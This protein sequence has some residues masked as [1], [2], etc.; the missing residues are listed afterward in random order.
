MCISIGEMPRT[1]H[2]LEGD[3]VMESAQK[4]GDVY[5]TSFGLSNHALSRRKATGDDRDTVVIFRPL[6]TAKELAEMEND[7]RALRVPGPE[8][9]TARMRTSPRGGVVGFY[10]RLEKFILKGP[11]AP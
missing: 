11:I 8:N 1:F 9:R 3:T 7:L 5:F 4:N 6:V 10:D 2:I